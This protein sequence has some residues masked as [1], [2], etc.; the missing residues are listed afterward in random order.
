MVWA[1]I[2]KGTFSSK[3][4]PRSFHEILINRGTS[5]I[6]THIYIYIYI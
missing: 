3:F 4:H 1:E 6:H 2:G 5:C